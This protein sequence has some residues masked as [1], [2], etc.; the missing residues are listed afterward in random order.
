MHGEVFELDLPER[1]RSYTEHSYKLTH[2]D[3]KTYTFKSIKSELRRQIKIEEMAKEKLNKRKRKEMALAT[4][5]AENPE[6]KIDEDAFL[7]KSNMFALDLYNG[8][9]WNRRPLEI[10]FP[11]RIL[12][13]IFKATLLTLLM[14]L[15]SLVMVL[16]IVFPYVGNVDPKY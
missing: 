1:P 13:Y 12:L 4:L 8:G 6:I 16:D 10:I 9:I 15:A 7:G 2:I 11:C 3:K 14:N 5:R